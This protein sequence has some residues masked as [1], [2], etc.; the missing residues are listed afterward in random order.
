MKIIKGFRFI[1][2]IDNKENKKFSVFGVSDIMYYNAPISKQVEEFFEDTPYEDGDKFNSGERKLKIK[3][4]SEEEKNQLSYLFIREG[5]KIRSKVS[6]YYEEYQYR[7]RYF[8][9]NYKFSPS[10]FGDLFPYGNYFT[11]YLRKKDVLKFM[12]FL[13][14]LSKKYK[15]KTIYQDIRQSRNAYRCCDENCPAYIKKFK[16]K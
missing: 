11:L 15:Y 2:E 13:K 14:V 8:T 4:N 5:F 12:T 7:R 10:L 1:L 16:L 3:V 9:E 6:E